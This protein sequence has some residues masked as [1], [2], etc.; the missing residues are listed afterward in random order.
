MGQDYS[1]L[2]NLLHEYRSFFISV[3]PEMEL[4]VDSLAENFQNGNPTDEE[5]RLTANMLDK[6]RAY[7]K[8]N[9]M[10][11]ETLFLIGLNLAQLQAELGDFK[12]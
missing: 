6:T 12:D 3:C 8:E 5:K 4:D 1:M 2:V 11:G 10:T 7:M 9:K